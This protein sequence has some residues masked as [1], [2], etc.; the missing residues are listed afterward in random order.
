MTLVLLLL[1][2]NLLV[3]AV[4]AVNCFHTQPNASCHVCADVWWCASCII[5]MCCYTENQLVMKYSIW[6]FYHVF[7][8]LDWIALLNY[9]F[10][11]ITLGLCEGLLLYILTLFILL[12][13]A[14]AQC[15]H[16]PK[17]HLD[18]WTDLISHLLINCLKFFYVSNF[19][20]WVWKFVWF[21]RWVLLLVWKNELKCS[22]L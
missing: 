17:L 12:Y 9:L 7:F 20:R 14:V 11:G 2:V 3:F 6:V 4:F 5:Y 8:F 18:Q 16:L 19:N 13:G 22:F 10:T 21:S 1:Y 15:H